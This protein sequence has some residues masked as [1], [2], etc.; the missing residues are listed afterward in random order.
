MTDPGCHSS[1]SVM[2]PGQEAPGLLTT[3]AWAPP[4]SWWG[5]QMQA[6]GLPLGGGLL[7]PVG[8]LG[9]VIHVLPK[10]SHLT[11]SFL[12]VSVIY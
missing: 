3:P 8:P 1:Q 11:C 7:L 4:P 9:P 12:S 6:L 10:A 2:G 5:A